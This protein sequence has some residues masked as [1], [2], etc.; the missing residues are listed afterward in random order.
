[1][2]EKTR[3]LAFF[4]VFCEKWVISRSW[5]LFFSKIS[6][7]GVFSSIFCWFT[8]AIYEL[9]EKK[10]LYFSWILWKKCEDFACENEFWTFCRLIENTFC[11]NLD[12]HF[13]AFSKSYISFDYISEFCVFDS[14]IPFLFSIPTFWYNLLDPFWNLLFIITEMEQK[15]RINTKMRFLRDQKSAR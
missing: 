4:C 13:Q 10:N 11:G 6:K 3:F 15:I 12:V 1:M 8:G 2:D 9:D 7:K 5:K 14:A